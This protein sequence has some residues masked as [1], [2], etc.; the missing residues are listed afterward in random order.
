MPRITRYVPSRHTARIKEPVIGGA[1]WDVRKA[2]EKKLKTKH[3]KISPRYQQFMD[4]TLTMDDLDDEEIMRGQIRAK[5]GSF[6]GQPPQMVPREFSR[7]LIIARQDVFNK[8]IAPM[9]VTALNT[10][11]EVMGGRGRLGSQDS[12]RV[13]AAKLVLE[14]AIGRVPEQIQIQA[15]IQTWEKYANEVLVDIEPDKEIEP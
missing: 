3:Y 5:D 9:V 12:A 13:S 1:D 14:R 15:E 7:Q 6:R 8:T 11:N 10:L 4:G 2:A